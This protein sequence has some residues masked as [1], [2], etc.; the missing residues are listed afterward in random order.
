MNPIACGC[1]VHEDLPG[2]E[3]L[4]KYLSESSPGRMPKKVV[5][6]EIQLFQLKDLVPAMMPQGCGTSGQGICREAI[7]AASSMPA[8]PYRRLWP[9]MCCGGMLN[10]WE[11][12]N[13]QDQHVLHDEH[14]VNP[15]FIKITV[16]DRNA[17]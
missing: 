3:Y 16:G 17:E 11:T 15:H 2:P 9:K 8:W 1:N 5:S 10:S 12:V 14:I 6:Q 13:H 4:S 7:S